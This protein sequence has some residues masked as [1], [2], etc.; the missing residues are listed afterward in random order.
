MDELEST[1]AEPETVET[2]GPSAEE[3]LSAELEQIYDAHTGENE[4]A[5]QPEAPAQPQASTPDAQQQPAPEPVQPVAAPA[6]WGKDAQ[7]VFSQLPAPLQAEVAKRETE[8]ERVVQQAFQERQQM[9]Q[10]RQALEPVVQGFND[11][12]PYFNTFRK[13][14]G[15]PMWGDQRAMMQEIKDVLATKQLLFRDPKAGLQ[16]I[17]TWAQQAGLNL[18]GSEGQQIDPE[19]LRLRQRLA[20]LEQDN[21][22]RDTAERERQAETQR[23]EAVQRVAYGLNDF[24]QAKSADGQPLY[25]HL[26]GEF[27]AQVG[28]MMGRWMRANAGPD[29]ITPELFKA[30]Y[31]TAVFSVEG[32]REAEMKAREAARVEQFK[33]NSERARKAAGINPRPGRAPDVDPQKPVEELYEDI[34]RKYNTA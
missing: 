29:G 13:A 15:S 6:S 34:W 26:F 10:A 22:R 4:A 5:P 1:A 8:R 9:Q 23:Q 14:D 11:L 30:A 17:L 24:A 31:E 19:T 3:S 20:Q 27:G 32:T 21:Q 12:S 2:E 18:D 28:E 7:A 25:P 33:K 16:A